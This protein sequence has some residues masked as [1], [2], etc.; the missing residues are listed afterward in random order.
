[1]KGLYSTL[2]LFHLHHNKGPI[3]RTQRKKLKGK[4]NNNPLLSGS[5]ME[6]KRYGLWT[7]TKSNYS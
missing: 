4:D 2:H 6:W 1:M 7:S 3:Y 5:Y